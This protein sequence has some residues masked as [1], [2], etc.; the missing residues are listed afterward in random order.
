MGTRFKSI[1]AQG[2]CSSLPGDSL[3]THLRQLATARGS[4]SDSQRG[5]GRWWQVSRSCG[6]FEGLFPGSELVEASRGIQLGPCHV[7]PGPA[8]VAT[9]CALPCSSKPDTHLYH[10]PSQEDR[11]PTH[12]W[13]PSDHI[14][15][16][17]MQLHKG[18]LTPRGISA[19]TRP[20]G[21]KLCFL[22]AASTQQSIR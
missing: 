5:S 12:W 13:Q 17:H 6:P 22:R 19:G 7:H 8:E 4:C 2:H 1:S 11:E 16:Q 18:H 3:R 21:G 14:G 10:R 20:C 15:A 9:H